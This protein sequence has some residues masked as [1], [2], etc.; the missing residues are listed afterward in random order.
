MFA[1]LLSTEDWNWFYHR[2]SLQ[3]LVES[4]FISGTV[5]LKYSR[6]KTK[7]QK[8]PGNGRQGPLPSFQSS[9]ISYKQ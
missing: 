7:E 8:I 9:N 6:I 2:V 1:F 4:M 3:R 5:D